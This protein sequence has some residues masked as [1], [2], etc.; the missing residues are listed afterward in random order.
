MV[1]ALV[2]DEATLKRYFPEGDSVRLQ[3]AN[4]EMAPLYVAADR[5]RVQGVVVGLMRRY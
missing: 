5:L 2:D 4:R 3:P 1:V